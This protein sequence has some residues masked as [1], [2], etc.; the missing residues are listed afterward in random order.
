LLSWG[1]E[2]FILKYD[3]VFSA[4]QFL[5]STDRTHLISGDILRARFFVAHFGLISLVFMAQA[6]LCMIFRN[7]VASKYSPKLNSQR[8]V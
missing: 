7:V 8:G 6:P 4:M 3:T 2:Q 1:T 5:L